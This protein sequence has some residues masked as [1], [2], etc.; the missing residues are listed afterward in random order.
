MDTTSYLLAKTYVSET[1]A[2]VGALKGKSAYEVAQMYG[3][4][5]SEQDWLTSLNGITPH[6]G[7]NGHWFID[8]QDT[9]VVAAPNLSGYFSEANLN[10]LTKE[11]ILEI[12]K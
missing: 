7:E 6:I 9:G 2:G 3:F 11:E 12:C 10:A 4:S 1:L 5:G 8:T